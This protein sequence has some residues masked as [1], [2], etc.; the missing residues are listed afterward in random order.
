MLSG[1]YKRASTTWNNISMNFEQ[2]DDKKSVI[3]HYPIV[4][5]NFV[6]YRSRAYD[7]LPFFHGVLLRQHEHYDGSRGHVR[8]QMR[9]TQFAE[10]IFIEFWNLF[11]CKLKPTCLTNRETFRAYLMLDLRS[12]DHCFRL[13]YGQGAFDFRFLL[14]S[15][16]NFVAV[17]AN[18][19]RYETLFLAGTIAFRGTNKFILLDYQDDY[20]FVTYD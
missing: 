11:G 20:L 15:L 18:H 6:K 19:W 13:Y 12:V 5:T 14:D 9:K 10:V 16:F 7:S 3:K 4:L 2:V 1:K 8:H 17:E